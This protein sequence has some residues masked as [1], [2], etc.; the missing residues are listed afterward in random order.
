MSAF[1]D[2]RLCDVL[3]H[4]GNNKRNNFNVMD[5]DG[6]APVKVEVSTTHF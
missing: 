2:A 3:V 6:V 1:L 4:V 5:K